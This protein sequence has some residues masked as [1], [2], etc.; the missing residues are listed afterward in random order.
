M[1]LRTHF[2]TAYKRLREVEDTS[3][4]STDERV[5]TMVAE[6]LEH[7]RACE[8]LIKELSIFSTNEELEDINPGDLKYLLVPYIHAELIELQV[9][10]QH[11]L[12]HLRAAKVLLERFL[13]SLANVGLIR[14]AEATELQG[15]GPPVPPTAKRELKIARIKA[16]RAVRAEMEAAAAKLERARGRS[17]DAEDDRDVDELERDHAQHWLHVAKFGAADSLASIATEL[18]MLE[19]VEKR[20]RED[21]QF[22]REEPRPPPDLNAPARP[23]DAFHIPHHTNRDAYDR[24]MEQVHTGRI[25]G[26]HTIELD[27]WMQQEAQ[28]V[29]QEQL[30]QQEAAALRAAAEERKQGEPQTALEEAEE[31]AERAK[32]MSFDEFKDANARGSG[33]MHKRG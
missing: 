33:N 32:A 2:E 22:G 6:G 26:M 10:E 8:R 23:L 27:D 18:P 20:R 1:N 30:H 28:R 29:T 17:G 7:A 24:V 25:P 19:E 4:D 14:E 9:D 12:N 5:L 13:D 21:P 31:L 3:L 11:R 16:E 15:A